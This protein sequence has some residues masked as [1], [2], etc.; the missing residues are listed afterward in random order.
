MM[1]NCKECLCEKVCSVIRKEVIENLKD[2][3]TE[4]DIPF[5]DEVKR[6]WVQ[7]DNILKEKAGDAG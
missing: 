6:I 3:I 7:M 5:T 1:A 2:Y 4:N